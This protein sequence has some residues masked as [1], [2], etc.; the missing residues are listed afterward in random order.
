MTDSDGKSKFS[1][2]KFPSQEKQPGRRAQWARACARVDPITRKP[3][4]QGHR[5]ICVHLLGTLH[6][7]SWQADLRHDPNP[8]P[9]EYRNN[10]LWMRVSSK[11]KL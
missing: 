4:T 5:A 7:W 9:A 10:F 11:T 1:F 3:W 2:F 8:N 6:F